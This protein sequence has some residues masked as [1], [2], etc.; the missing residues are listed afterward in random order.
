MKK[1]YVAIEEPANW[2]NGDIFTEI[3]DTPEEATRAAEKTWQYLT[4]DEKKKNWV[5]SAVITEK[6]LMDDAIDEDGNIDWNAYNQYDDYE[7]NFDSNN[8]PGDDEEE[9]E[10]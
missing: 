2:A 3:F 4:A 10:E 9:E 1:K 7:G 6:D 5:H 8:L